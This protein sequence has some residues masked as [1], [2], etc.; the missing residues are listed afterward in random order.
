MKKLLPI[1]LLLLLLTACR[2]QPQEYESPDYQK[3]RDDF[4]PTEY[5]PT[6]P[7]TDPDEP[8]ETVVVTPIMPLK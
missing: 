6:L 4:A 7:P 1:F 8:T 5:V 3:I 2:E